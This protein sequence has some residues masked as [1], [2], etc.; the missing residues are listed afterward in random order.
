MK[1]ILV[2]IFVIVF[3]VSM[4]L[5]GIGCK[6]EKAEESAAEEVAEETAAEDVFI[7]FS[8]YDMKYGFF[9]LMDAGAKDYAAEK[10]WEY[11]THDEKS[12]ET[13]MV[14]GC[15]DLINQGI[16]ALLVSPFKPEALGPVVEAAHAKGIPVIIDDIGTG[17]YDYDAFIISDNVGGGEIAGEYVIGLMEEAGT[18]AAPVEV[19]LIRNDPSNVAGHSR[20][21]GFVDVCEAA[22]YTVV[23]DVSAQEATADAAYPIATDILTANPD[24]VAIFCTN[25]NMATGTAQAAID[26]G[27]DDLIVIG[28][29]GSEIALEAIEAGT[30]VAT[31]MQFP[32]NMGVTAA[33]LADDFIN[34][35]TPKFDDSETKTIYVPVDI[36]DINNIDI[37]W[38]EVEKGK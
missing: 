36:I 20:G 16:D 9:R 25:D 26:S 2:W 23:K 4:S 17:D 29:D 6:A 19:A 32:Y 3:I 21:F 8:L 15:E 12:D 30:M 1:R 35:V 5:V 31:V 28:F 13:T 34:G 18:D 11:V 27:R 7:G 38:A 10:G 24:L 14:T 22:G 37:A 33:E